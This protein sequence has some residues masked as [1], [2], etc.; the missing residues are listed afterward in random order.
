MVSSKALI[1][2]GGWINMKKATFW[3]AL[4]CMMACLLCGTAT[5]VEV[6]DGTVAETFA[7]GSGTEDNPYL[8]SNGAQ[9]ALV[10]EYH[11]QHA[12]FKLSADIYLNDTTDWKDWTAQSG[13][14]NIW[15]PICVGEEGKFYGVLD[16]DGHTVYGMYISEPTDREQVALIS[17]AGNGAVIKNL[18][19][20]E[21]SVFGG[22]KI[23]ALL[24]KGYNASVI[25]CHNGGN[26]TGTGMETG[27]LISH[28]YD[29][30]LVRDCSNSG[31]VRNVND[32]Y[33]DVNAAIRTAG[34]VGFA[35]NASVIE[36]CVNTGH[37]S[38][39]ASQIGGIVG[40][41]FGVTVT[42]CENRGLVEI[43]YSEGHTPDEIAGI[44]GSAGDEIVIA[45]CSNYGTVRGYA[46]RIGGIFGSTFS[47]GHIRGCENHGDVSNVTPGE[48]NYD[49][50]G[51]IAGIAQGNC[52]FY[53]CIN[54]GKVT[55][56]RG[57]GGI[58][59][60]FE[61]ITITACI[62]YAAISG[63][64]SDSCVGGIVGDVFGGVVDGNLN[65]GA[66]SGNRS[67]G[68]I[69]G[70][71]QQG[72]VR[73]CQ[74]I[75]TVSATENNAGGI[76]GAYQSAIVNCRNSG[77]VSGEKYVGG[78]GGMCSY[79]KGGASVRNCWSSGTITADDTSNF[80]AIAGRVKECVIENCS[81]LSGV[82]GEKS[83][84]TALT[85]EIPEEY[86]KSTEYLAEL[87]D[88]VLENQRPA[89]GF[90]SWETNTEG[91][92]APVGEVPDYTPV[93]GNLTL[94]QPKNGTAVLSVDSAWTETEITVTVTADT[95]YI[96]YQVWYCT[97]EAPDELVYAEITG[98]NTFEFPMPYGDAEV[99]TSCLALP[100]NTAWDGSVAES[101]AGGDGT[102]NNPYLIGNGAQFALLEKYRNDDGYFR[103]IAD[104]YLNDTADWNNWTAENAPDNIWK[105]I[106]Y[107]SGTLD[108]DGYTIYGLYTDASRSEQGLFQQTQNGAYLKNLNIAQ[109]KL[110]GTKRV[111]AFVG[112][113]QCDV[114]NC[115]S[116]AEV[117]ASDK[118]SGGIAGSHE[119]TTAAITDCINYGTVCSSSYSVGGIVG[120]T[121]ADL[122]D[123]ANY[124]TVSSTLT[125]HP[126]G[127]NWDIRVGGI[128]GE[129]S[130][131]VERC[132][133]YGS[134]SGYFGI[135]GIAGQAMGYFSDCTNHGEVTALYH[136]TNASSGWNAGGIACSVSRGATLYNCVNYGEV[137]SVERAGGICAQMGG[138]SNDSDNR[139]AGCVNHGA[140]YVQTSY[141]GG[142]VGFMSAGSVTCTVE[143]CVNYGAVANG[144]TESNRSVGGV[145][146]YAQSRTGGF[147]LIR[148]CYNTG[149]ITGGSRIGG[150]AGDLW[151]RD[152]NCR[153]VLENCY[154]TGKVLGALYVGAVIGR[155]GT[156]GT[157]T[158]QVI[159]RNCYALDGG[160]HPEGAIYNGPG[161]ETVNNI[162]SLTA[163][164]MAQ[165][166][167]FVGFDFENVWY[168]AGD[169]SF[170]TLLQVESS[171]QIGE[172][173]SFEVY[174]NGAISVTADASIEEPIYALVVSYENGQM[175]GCDV[176]QL[177]A[178]QSKMLHLQDQGNSMKLFALSGQHHPLSG[179]V[180]IT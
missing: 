16:G 33:T 103:L 62:N 29:E 180:N 7:G 73:N 47:G 71:L 104:V 120:Q 94:H 10:N 37:I 151:T 155:L 32:T 64:K 116:S 165:P 49:C 106:T 158:A 81:Y 9:L 2:H 141:V 25:N 161:I 149:S 137:T 40:Q 83:V 128:A 107:L 96:P 132:E 17:Y 93:V 30:C 36:N 163:T 84:D 55:S 69:V 123:C 154:S 179:T 142:I 160:A 111:A 13:P 46:T 54:Y 70:A 50:V 108:G 98:K 90:A 18:S 22:E 178:S 91:Y 34:I 126:N 1:N 167:N 68:G 65:E 31:T 156:E 119:S 14:T 112:R 72:W 101:F 87:N 63:G 86:L 174:Q 115:T 48:Y 125:A 121:S 109:S 92:P 134:V 61:G 85:Q 23:A 67:V 79:T 56:F 78:I 53:D 5:A 144:G 35:M 38:S 60:R 136:E 8:I 175:V 15:T 171:G 4:L 57:V 173:L 95:G 150:V 113:N 162:K 164:Q 176:V 135:G 172:V 59:G 159:A 26:V 148:D 89:T 114:I 99:F 143:Q 139:I 43:L 145:A 21:S 77:A 80:G 27:G 82:C 129:A 102:E 168:C 88:W 133:N 130:G 146:G 170:P 97:A 45:D 12:Y 138:S 75:G 177:S 147:A 131:N 28:V 51:G 152:A 6:W 58:V 166:S 100:E 66:I 19:I 127:S 39:Y 105:P 76:A 110:Y 153:T 122:Y 3:F 41:G 20:M 124:G 157:D 140:V 52:D 117:Y 118:Y 24:G 42:G 74:N 169:G 11:G 44:V